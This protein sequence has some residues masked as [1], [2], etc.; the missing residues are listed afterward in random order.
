MPLFRG[1]KRWPLVVAGLFLSSML[2]A[3]CGE[4]SP[5]ILN[6]A[7]PVAQSESGV[8]YLILIIATVIFVG[9]E[10]WLLY[11]IFRYRERPACPIRG[12]F[13][14]APGSRCSGR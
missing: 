5:S 2:L 10:A 11:S 1:A 3:A 13:M 12:R 7:G 14:A 9:V 4:N 8:F 6:T